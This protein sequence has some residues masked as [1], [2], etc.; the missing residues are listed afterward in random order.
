MYQDIYS[1]NIKIFFNS[2]VVI[3]S[4]LVKINYRVSAIIRRVN[5]KLQELCQLH[6]FTY[7]SN[8]E[9]TR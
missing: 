3:S 6:N 7:I 9:T 5:D 2:E 4:I 1:I 8:D